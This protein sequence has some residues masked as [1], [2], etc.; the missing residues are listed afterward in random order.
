MSSSLRQAGR[1]ARQ[2]VLALGVSAAALAP[3]WTAVAPTTAAAVE[4][5]AARAFVTETADEVLGLI[6]ATG[7]DSEKRRTMRGL[8]QR[9]S[10]VEDIARV[11]IGRTW[12]GMTSSQ[13]SRYVDAFL[14]LV[15]RQTVAGFKNYSGE[16]LRIIGAVDKGRGGVFVQTLINSAQGGEGPIKVDWRIIDRN[17]P[18]QLFDVYVDGVSLL[19]TQRQTFASR[20]ERLGGD[21]DALI[22]QLENEAS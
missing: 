2:I 10:A 18:L 5:G 21:V 4:V 19:T 3:V 1:R 8:L 13:K 17:G 20:L 11:A 12:E 22:S 15:T 7:S 16:T 9:K 6:R 14:S